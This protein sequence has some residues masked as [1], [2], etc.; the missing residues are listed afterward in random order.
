[1][2]ANLVGLNK[3]KTSKSVVKL[4]LLVIAGRL[5]NVF[6]YFSQGLVCE[7]KKNI[8]FT[9]TVQSKLPLSLNITLGLC[10]CAP[11]CTRVVEK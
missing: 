5:T 10:M 9:V 1:M 11:A 3:R 8:L 4:H 7:D 6:Q 2:A